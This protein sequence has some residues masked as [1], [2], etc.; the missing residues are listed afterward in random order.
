MSRSA[1]KGSAH[2]S[3]KCAAQAWDEEAGEIVRSFN[4]LHP[5]YPHQEIVLFTPDI[6]DGFDENGKRRFCPLLYE[7]LKMRVVMDAGGSIRPYLG[8]VIS[9]IP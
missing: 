3:A 1:E 4:V 5:T 8:H 9:N 6:E 2:R 7:E